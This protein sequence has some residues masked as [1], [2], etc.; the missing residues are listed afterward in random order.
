[1][2]GRWSEKRRC[3]Y[4]QLRRGSLPLRLDRSAGLPLYA[5]AV[6]VA[7]R[8]RLVRALMDSRL[9]SALLMIG[10]FVTAPAV[11]EDRAG[12]ESPAATRPSMLGEF[13]DPELKFAEG[14]G[15]YLR[16]ADAA[17]T[18]GLLFF[19]KLGDLKESGWICLDG[20]VVEVSKEKPHS[21]KVEN[22]E[23]VRVQSYRSADATVQ[24]ELIQQQLNEAEETGTYA[25][26][27]TVSS[28]DRTE[29]VQVTG[30]CGC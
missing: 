10:V 3:S 25:G 6:M 12:V 14:C 1:M 23:T 21:T 16:R 9:L 5:A 29:T 13:F 11:A 7:F 8:L 28:S 26:E 30:T 2:T 17:E 24:V 19:G 27:I 15:C 18:D 20:K 4:E 22:D